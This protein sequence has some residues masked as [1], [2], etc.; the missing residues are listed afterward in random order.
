MPAT[1]TLELS[2]S[3]DSPFDLYVSAAGPTRAASVAAADCRADGA[4][5]TVRR[6]TVSSDAPTPW[7]VTLRSSQRADYRLESVGTPAPDA[8]PGGPPP[9][10]SPTSPAAPDTA[11]PGAGPPDDRT[12]DTVSPDAPVSDGAGPVRTG[13][14]PSALMLSLLAFAAGA[15]RARAAVAGRRADA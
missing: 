15:R 2:A 13:G 9:I 8:V 4:A 12:P 1:G 11:S 10:S 14:A 5:A 3:A 7:Y 6:C